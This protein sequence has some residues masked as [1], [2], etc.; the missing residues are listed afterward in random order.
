MFV[1]HV[2]ASVWVWAWVWV[3]ICARLRA[4]AVHKCTHPSTH[5]KMCEAPACPSLVQDEIDAIYDKINSIL[6]AEF[7]ASKA[8]VPKEKDWLSSHW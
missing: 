1:V 4:C 2:R 3:S 7:E 5:T 6:N 8:Y